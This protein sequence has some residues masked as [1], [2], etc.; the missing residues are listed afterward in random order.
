MFLRSRYMHGF[1]KHDFVKEP[2]CLDVK[3]I[4]VS[5][6]L[7]SIK[8]SER[9]MFFGDEVLYFEL[10]CISCGVFI[11]YCNSFNFVVYS[12][13]RH[14]IVPIH[15][16][17][18]VDFPRVIFGDRRTLDPYICCPQQSLFYRSI[19]LICPSIV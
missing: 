15:P 12:I 3:L 2:Y 6:S 4:D 9:D 13:F 17:F 7:F 16:S 14:N 19:V 8:A 10:I 5:R 11:F 1:N 18:R